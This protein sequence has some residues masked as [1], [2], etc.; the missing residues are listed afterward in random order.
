MIAIPSGFGG[1]MENWGGIT[2]FESAL[3]YDPEKSSEQAKENIF[4][5]RGARNCAPVVW[6]SRDDGLVG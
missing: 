2:Y 1:A 5:R 4:A 6:R 3:L